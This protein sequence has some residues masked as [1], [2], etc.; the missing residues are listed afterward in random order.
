MLRMCLNGFML[1]SEKNGKFD[2]VKQ[3]LIALQANVRP[4]KSV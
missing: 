2:E 1:R 3:W 4:Y